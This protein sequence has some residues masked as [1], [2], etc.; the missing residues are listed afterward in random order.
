LPSG[1]LPDLFGERRQRA[2]IAQLGAFKAVVANDDMIQIAMLKDNLGRADR[3]TI[4][5]VVA[6]ILQ[7]DICPVISSDDGILRAC[8]QAF[9]ALSADPGLVLT[10]LRKASLN[11]KACLFG[12]DL[13][14][15]ADSADLHAQTAAA[16]FAG[17][18]PKSLNF[19]NLSVLINLPGDPDHSYNH[20]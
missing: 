6:F 2:R 12:I 1:T 15:M 20:N 8:L 5:A 14:K 10:R 7:D 3:N 16:A 4:A 19:H 11:S 18:Y 17:Y 9:A 13:F